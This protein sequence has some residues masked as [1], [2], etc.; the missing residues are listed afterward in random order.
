[1]NPEHFFFFV[2]PPHKI[3]PMEAEKNMHSDL[4]TYVVVREQ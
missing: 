1:M 2:L 4:E 3:E